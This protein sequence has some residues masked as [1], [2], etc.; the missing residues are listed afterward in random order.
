MLN[1]DALFYYY[2]ALVSLTLSL[3][4]NTG[5]KNVRNHFVSFGWKQGLCKQE[6]FELY[7]DNAS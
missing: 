3:L 7:Q 5:R 2:V 4:N 6:A 1:V